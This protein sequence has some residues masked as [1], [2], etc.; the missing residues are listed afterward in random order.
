MIQSKV[1]ITILYDIIAL[2]FAPVT[3]TLILQLYPK[4]E[5]FRTK[6][7]LLDQLCFNKCKAR[8]FS[9]HSLV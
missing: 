9:T 8:N 6:V 1:V 7:E 4:N 3:K 2:K 5:T